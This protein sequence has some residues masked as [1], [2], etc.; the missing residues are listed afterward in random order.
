MSDR[1]AEMKATVEALDKQLVG[2]YE[3]ALSDV[4]WL[5]SEV[6]RLKAEKRAHPYWTQKETD[7]YAENCRLRSAL[8]TVLDTAG[9]RAEREALQA[10][11]AKMAAADY[12]DLVGPY[13]E[14]AAALRG[15]RQT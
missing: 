7:L 15:E 3:F 5:I 6:E 4:A 8:G 1:L 13:Q 12:H 10:F 2:W 14:Q 9:L 11:V